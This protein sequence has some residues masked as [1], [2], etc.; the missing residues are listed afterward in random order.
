MAEDKKVAIEV[1]VKGT[2]QSLKSVKD[3]KDAIK[4]LQN[5]VENSDIGS[6]Q[7]KQA[8]ENLDKL[9]T[10]LKQVTQTE[11]Q[12][13]KSLE[14]VTKA[15]KEAI[16]ETQDLRK[17]FEV[18]EDELFLLA[19]Q[20]KQNTKQF[21]DLTIEAAALNKRID[22]V[23]STLGG[24]DADR[25]SMGYAKL[26]DGLKNLD[27]KSV[28]E[29]LF[30]MK[31]ALA[32]TGIMLVVQGV[33]YLYENF[34][35]LSKGSG[36]LAKSLRFV[37]DIIADILKYGEQMLNFVTDFIGVTTEAE[38]AAEEAAVKFAKE[39]EKAINGVSAALDNQSIAYDKQMAI[40]KAAGKDVSKLEKE[41]LENI[42]KTND[43][44]VKQLSVLDL[45][46]EKTKQRLLAAAK[47]SYDAREQLKVNEAA[48]QKEKEDKQK[49][50]NDKY[51]AAQK[52]LNEDLLADEKST[53]AKTLEIRASNR[54]AQEAEDARIAKEKEEQ[55]KLDAQ[56]Q[57]D[58]MKS[59]G[60]EEN[61]F[62]VSQAEFDKELVKLTEAQKVDITRNALQSVQQLSDIFFMFKSQKAEKGS[63]QEED[64]A[65]KQ[66]NFNKGLQLGL[67]AIDGFK[68]ITSSLAQS[69]IAVGVVPNPAGIASL[70]FAS[71]TTA[72]NIAKIAASQFKSS[73]G[74]GGVSAPSAP[75]ITIPAPPVISTASN[76]LNSNT[77][78]DENGKR[79]GGEQK[80]TISINAT[81]GVDE[82]KRKMDKVDVLEKQSTF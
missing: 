9:N 68:S 41:K 46:E 34:E 78:F 52:K 24:G 28:K 44:I 25:A 76:N 32:A 61:A 56:A 37:G 58:Y 15:E 65:R 79:I 45:N 13:A 66:F 36:G 35:R 8:V 2:E 30:A 11:E 21:R 4:N 72:A 29:G 22:E 19:G 73:G 55:L 67:A 77:S 26:N 1:E 51:L 20:G 81:I 31:T 82:V 40:L 18:L 23:N 70:A 71:I 64:L 16:K 60:N 49:S 17:Q 27:F 54:A 62:K 53:W 48:A 57:L 63:K 39:T 7:Y 14:D 47:A 43:A 75:N 33:T 6:E 50:N 74:G 38:R 3:L 12:Y 10:K 5:E 80:Q 42:I 59:V 69:P